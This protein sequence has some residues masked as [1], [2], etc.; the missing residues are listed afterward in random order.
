M[1]EENKAADSKINL[2]ESTIKRIGGY[3]HRVIP[4][5]DVTGEI[6]SYT[7]KPIMVEFKPRIFCRSL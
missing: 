2:E 6:I 1:S 7:M 4:I 5:A 3:L